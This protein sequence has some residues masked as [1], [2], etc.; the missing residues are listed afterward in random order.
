MYCAGRRNVFRRRRAFKLEFEGKTIRRDYYS[1]YGVLGVLQRFPCLS[2]S[3]RLV[4]EQDL[5]QKSHR[6]QRNGQVVLEL[7]D[8]ASA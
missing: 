6:M 2:R 8:C 7:V 4:L 3:R 5:C 1:H